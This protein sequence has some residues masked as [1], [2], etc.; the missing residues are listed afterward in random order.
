ME[1]SLAESLALAEKLGR[2]F[3]AIGARYA[4]GGS[5]ASSL[6]GYPRSTLDVDMVAALR[7][8]HV[9]GLVD[10]LSEGFY[11]SE[12]AIRSAV[13]QRASFNVVEL[14]TMLKVDIFV[15]GE[16]GL[17][18]LERA[19]AVETP[20]G[21]RFLVVSAEDIV[22]QKLRW[23]RLGGETSE[24]QWR[25]LVG[26][27]EVQGEGIDREALRERSLAVGVSDLLERALQTATPGGSRE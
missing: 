6:H 4:V 7:S 14:A 25:D 10:A 22:V 2:I 13:G 9:P 19:I 3:D 26:V 27:L 24:R 20:D 21:H 1:V 18:E 12:A 16:V 5:V 11:L 17:G 8:H 23:F 15:A